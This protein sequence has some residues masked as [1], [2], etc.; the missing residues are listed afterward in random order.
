M[1]L[2]RT[3]YPLSLRGAAKRRG[4]LVVADSAASR[5]P[6]KSGPQGLASGGRNDNNF[7]PAPFD[8]QQ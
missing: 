3:N 8:L 5:L 6:P 7:E 1:K 2:V 4:N